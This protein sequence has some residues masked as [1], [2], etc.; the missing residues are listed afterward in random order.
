[1]T[2]K[3]RILIAEDEAPIRLALCDSLEGAG[4]DVLPAED[5][6]R[7]LEL[8]LSQEVDLALL[9]INMP[10]ISGF[11]LLR[12]ISRECPGTPCIILTAHG[13]EQDRVKGLELGADDYVVK[14]FSIAELLAR[15]T[16]VLRRSPTRRRVGAEALSFDGAHLDPDQRQIRYSDGHTATLSEKECELLRYLL[17]HPNRV[18]SQEELLLRVWGSSSRV[19]QTRTVAVT[20]TRLKDKIGKQA[21][22]HI[23]NIR[24]RG[25]RWND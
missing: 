18:I 1:M 6:R 21:S 15:I 11:K 10:E 12:I 24:G 25:Y 2:T 13:E 7:A 5:G 17:A 16:A 23:E 22:A 8:L 20:L 14:P 9:D 4:Y 19:G 3:R